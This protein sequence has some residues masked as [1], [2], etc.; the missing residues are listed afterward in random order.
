MLGGINGSIITSQCIYHK[1]IRDFGSG[2]PGLTN[3]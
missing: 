1:D 3:F 2:N